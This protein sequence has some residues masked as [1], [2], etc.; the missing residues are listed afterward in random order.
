MTSSDLVQTFAL[1]TLCELLFQSA[2]DHVSEA[3]LLGSRHGAVQFSGSGIDFL[4]QS[5][6]LAGQ[7]RSQDRR[8]EEDAAREQ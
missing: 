8:T 3:V 4:G 2:I 6:G 1:F 7:L 5:D